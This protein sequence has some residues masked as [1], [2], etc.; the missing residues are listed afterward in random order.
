MAQII[1]GQ[2]L[3][4]KNQSNPSRLTRFRNHGFNQKQ[5]SLIKAGFV[6]FASINHFAYAVRGTLLLFKTRKR[7]E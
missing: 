6:R 3:G 7:F 4:H 2:G 1:E 5:A